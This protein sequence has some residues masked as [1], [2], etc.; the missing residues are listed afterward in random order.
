AKV[1]DHIEASGKSVGKSRSG[2]AARGDY[3]SRSLSRIHI[4]LRS[5]LQRQYRIRR[6]SK[7]AAHHIAS[8]G[9]E[10][11]KHIRCGG[12]LAASN[13]HAQTVP[14]SQL[15]WSQSLVCGPVM[16]AT[17]AADPPKLNAPTP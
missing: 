16:G 7:C 17:G 12:R 13:R 2:H 9:Y 15:N 8:L 6:Q 14:S 5:S 11:P 4:S 3:G 10:L 1:I